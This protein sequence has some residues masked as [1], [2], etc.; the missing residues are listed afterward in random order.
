LRDGGI[1]RWGDIAIAHLREQVGCVRESLCVVYHWP[2]YVIEGHK[3]F[4]RR[5]QLRVEYR[6]D[7]SR[8][9]VQIGRF[10][11][12]VSRFPFPDS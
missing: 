11:F 9:L 3:L 4:A 1:G 6:L 2:S 12:P 7:P 5:T 8:L 10:L